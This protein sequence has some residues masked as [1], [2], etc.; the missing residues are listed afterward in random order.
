[1]RRRELWYRTCS[2]PS[3]QDFG[4]TGGVSGRGG[5]FELSA[6][7]PVS[8][9]VIWKLLYVLGFQVL[10][11]SPLRTFLLVIVDHF[12]PVLLM[13]TASS[14]VNYT[15]LKPYRDSRLWLRHFMLP[16][17]PLRYGAT[18]LSTY[19]PLS[20]AQVLHPASCFRTWVKG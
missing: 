19:Q 3:C 8:M 17:C 12:G 20:R 10:Y 15:E 7:K 18:V 2:V 11:T 6:R 5:L 9:L 13:I 14:E 1:V 16:T 4:V